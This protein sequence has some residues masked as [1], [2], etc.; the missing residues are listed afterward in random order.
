MLGLNP[1]KRP[2]GEPRVH[3]VVCAGRGVPPGAPL[4]AARFPSPRNLEFIGVE[5]CGDDTDTVIPLIPFRRLVIPIG[6]VE[7]RLNRADDPVLK[8][9]WV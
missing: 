8:T 4:P 6:R 5:R 3:D 7:Q 1:Y 2:R 9:P